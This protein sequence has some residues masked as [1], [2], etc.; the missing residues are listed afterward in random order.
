[1]T[2]K[3]LVKKWKVFNSRR[4]LFEIFIG[5]GIVISAVLLAWIAAFLFLKAWQI[6]LVIF[7]VMFSWLI[8]H[9]V[10]EEDKP[11]KRFKK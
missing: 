5:F 3:T 1:M 9:L 8:G 6:F 10:L 11:K 7:I 2:G 4:V